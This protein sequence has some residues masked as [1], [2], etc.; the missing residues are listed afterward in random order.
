MKNKMS[1]FIALISTLLIIVCFSSCA[2]GNT[3]IGLKAARYKE[4]AFTS[5]YSGTGVVCENEKWQ[6]LWDDSKKQVSFKDKANDV[7]WGQIPTE[8]LT[9]DKYININNAFKSPISCTTITRMMLT[10][11]DLLHLPMPYATVWFT[12]MP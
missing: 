12:Q 1:R 3:D 7:V 9:D 2:S 6:L 11:A 4:D 5:D 10:R 8:A